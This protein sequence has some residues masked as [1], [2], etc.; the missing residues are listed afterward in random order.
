VRLCRLA[1]AILSKVAFWAREKVE[2]PL[3]PGVDD[4]ALAL[5]ADA[6]ARTFR[7]EVLTTSAAAEVRSRH[8][9]RIVAD[10]R[11]NAGGHVARFDGPRGRPPLEAAFA[12]IGRRYGA[13]SVRLVRMSME[14]DPPRTSLH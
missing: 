6:W 11:P 13:A 12:Q 8:G 4:L 1:G 3:S 14:Y 7:A 9:L 5:H 2:F 10:A